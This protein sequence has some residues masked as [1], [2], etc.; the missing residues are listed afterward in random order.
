MFFCLFLICWMFPAVY[1]LI[2]SFYVDLNFNINLFFLLFH[3]GKKYPVPPKRSSNGAKSQLP[4]PGLSSTPSGSITPL[5][6]DRISR[7]FLSFFPF[8]HDVS[9]RRC[10]PSFTCDKTLYFLL[11]PYGTG[12]PLNCVHR[13]RRNHP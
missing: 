8:F 11:F 4:K 13:V 12:Q 6:S 7:K 3:G 2:G 1:R 10:R 5:P 9:L